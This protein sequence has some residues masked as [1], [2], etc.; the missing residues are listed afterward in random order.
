M[1]TSHRFQNAWSAVRQ[2]VV[3]SIQMFLRNGLQNHA[4]AT[5]LYFLLS[6]TPLLIL[7]TWA[8]QS[9]T[10]AG[11][12]S[13]PTAMLIGAFYEQFHLDTLAQMGVIPRQGSLSAGGVGLLTLLLSA[14]GLLNAIQGALGVIFAGERRRHLVLSWLIPL[15]I[16]P[17]ALAL[18]AVAIVLNT[19]LE[20]SMAQ[21]WLS[22]RNA[23]FASVLNSGAII[24]ILFGLVFFAY[25]QM[26]IE[27]PPL[28]PTLVCAALATVS[29][30]GLF[31]AMGNLLQV[32]QF[33]LVYGA[34]GGVI[35]ILMAVYFAAMLFYFWAQ[36]L[37][38]WA[39]VDI[40]ALERILI[41][42]DAAN[43]A[44][45][46]GRLMDIPGL[47]RLIDKYG[48]S[49]PAGSRL[50]HE[51]DT[52]DRTTF[53]ICAGRVQL[54]RHANEGERVIAELGI[55]DMFGEMAYLLG[56]G[57]TATAI[58]MEE[59]I[60]LSLPPEMLETLMRQSAP[61]ARDIIQSLCVRLERMNKG[62]SEIKPANTSM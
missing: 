35:F 23:L 29:L 57:R 34:I 19:V 52:D 58:A 4:A 40:W 18:L 54:T 25:H 46:S 41:A 6:A 56:E 60:V 22:G 14:R 61:V 7:L 47:S 26:P 24:T 9:L 2:T 44:I 53:F 59:V 30:L 49:F 48:R 1:N 21:E 12:T 39:Q 3:L 20:F 38:V 15:L 27:R 37:R 5:A 33:Q 8:A 43:N 36:W 55:G 31:A 62:I 45:K 32:E 13:L 50:I 28:R 10:Q 11:A 17:L 51:G 16:V 42:N